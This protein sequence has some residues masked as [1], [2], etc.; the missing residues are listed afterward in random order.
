MFLSYLSGEADRNISFELMKSFNILVTFLE[1]SGKYE[2]YILPF[3][4]GGI[5]DGNT[6]T[7]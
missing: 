5:V 1:L 3:S 4:S 6:E 2:S 7:T